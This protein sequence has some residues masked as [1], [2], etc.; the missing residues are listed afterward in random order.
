V[1]GD[2]FF[3]QRSQFWK[4]EERR[5]VPVKTAIA[6]AAVVGGVVVLS[7]WAMGL[8]GGSASSGSSG[9]GD[10][11]NIQVPMPLGIVINR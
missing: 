7:D 8:G 1:N 5:F 11:R 10:V 4:L 2:V 3:F 6:V 9:G